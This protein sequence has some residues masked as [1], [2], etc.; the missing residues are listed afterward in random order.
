VNELVGLLSREDQPQTHCSTRH[1]SRETVLAQSSFIQIIHRDLD[2]KYLFRLPTH[3]LP[4]IVSL[5][6]IH[7]S[8]GSVATLLMCRWI[9]DNHFIAICSQSVPVKEF[10]K[11]VNIWQRYAQ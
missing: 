6:Y 5:S 4:I 2:L 9:F 10:E 3:L 7:I 11:S 8:Q 1:I